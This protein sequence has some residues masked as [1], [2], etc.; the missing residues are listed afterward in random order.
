MSV[1]HL[2]GVNR[3]S[4]PYMARQLVR[5]A[6]RLGSPTLGLAYIA[7]LT[8]LL[9]KDAW[10][11]RLAPLAAVGRMA[12]TNYLL[13]SVIFVLLFFGYGLG[14]YG[15]VGAFGGFL[16][17]IP[18]IV[19]QILLSGW[20]LQRFRFGPVEWVWRCLTYGRVQP[21]LGK[22]AG[23]TPLTAR[24]MVPKIVPPSPTA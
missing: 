3:E 4:I 18:V 6:E 21:M 17:T 5:L 2:Y 8:L 13:Q 20:W 12:L 7:A 19:G 24:V 10:K 9:Q 11:K 22:S 14:L 15:K 23:L 16:L 1:R